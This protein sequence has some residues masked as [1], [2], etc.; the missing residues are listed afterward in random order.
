LEIKMLQLGR[1]I[2]QKLQGP[3]RDSVNQQI[4]LPA[5]SL[6]N[7]SRFL[8]QKRILDIVAHLEGDI[9]ECGIGQGRTLL[10]WSILTFAE[11]RN[12]RIWGF[13][14]FEGFPEPSP[15][16]TSPRNPQKGEWA[17]GGMRDLEN[18]LL[19]SGLPGEWIRARLT[20]VKGFFEDSLPKYAGGQ[21]ALLHI[22]A[23]LYQSYKTS[24]EI[25]YPQVCPGG[26]IALDEYMGTWEHHGF[27]GAKQAVDEFL[28]DQKLE[29]RR[30]PYF[31]K[32]YVV[33]PG[34]KS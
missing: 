17:A 9:V 2:W 4:S 14:S 21:I 5:F 22:D 1:Q 8:Y 34:A 16:D 11:N 6:H 24:L 19:A 31:G 7:G 3:A 10:F 32:Y 26:V 13:D 29:V 30:D 27:P 23:D 25:L 20:L 12:R 15:E 33:K 28:A 18:L